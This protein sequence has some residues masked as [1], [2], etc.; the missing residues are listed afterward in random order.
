[1]PFWPDGV[2]AERSIFGCPP[3]P[4]TVSPAALMAQVSVYVPGSIATVS[5]G[6]A[7]AMASHGFAYVFPGPTVSVAPRAGSAARHATRDETREACVRMMSSSFYASLLR[8]LP[9]GPGNYAAAP[10][11]QHRP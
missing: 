3:T 7:A 4:I 6:W 5:F 9:S 2:P 8:L 1:M 11:R 10:G